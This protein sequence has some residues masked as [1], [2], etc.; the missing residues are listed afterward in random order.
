MSPAAYTVSVL[1]KVPFSKEKR[2]YMSQTAAELDKVMQSMP[3]PPSHYVLKADM[4]EKMKYPLPQ[5][6]GPTELPEGF[7]RTQPSQDP[8]GSSSP[9]P[10]VISGQRH[11]P[12]K[13]ENGHQRIG[14]LL[15]WR[16]QDVYAC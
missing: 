10:E 7:V 14:S 5:Q 16:L 2:Q 9:A 3:F 12:L 6:D 1:L 8:E 11:R 4:M 13:T 15:R